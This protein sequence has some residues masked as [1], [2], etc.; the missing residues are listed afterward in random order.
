MKSY[1]INHQISGS[2]VH[3]ATPDG[4]SCPS[5]FISMVTDSGWTALQQIGMRD[6]SGQQWALVYRTKNIQTLVYDDAISIK[7]SRDVK[8]EQMF[9]GAYHRPADFEN[10]GTYQVGHI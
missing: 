5:Q 6:P 7:L 10:G 8:K 4:L 3:L 9:S 1:G 2:I